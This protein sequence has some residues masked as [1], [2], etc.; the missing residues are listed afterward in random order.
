MSLT[1]RS[2]QASSKYKLTM[3]LTSLTTQLTVLKHD[4]PRKR[5]GTCPLTFVHSVFAHD[6]TTA[7][8]RLGYNQYKLHVNKF[9]QQQI[10]GFR[11]EIRTAF[12]WVKTQ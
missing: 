1:T 12:L 11:R 8:R 3:H 10:S 9:G 5:E 6:Q 7:D 2:D 4:R